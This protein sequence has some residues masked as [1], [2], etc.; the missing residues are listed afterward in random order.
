MLY[1]YPPGQSPG[2]GKPR[3]FSVSSVIQFPDRRIQA[4]NIEKII[5]KSIEDPECDNVFFYSCPPN[6]NPSNTELLRVIR[7]Y[8]EEIDSLRLSCKGKVWSF[9]CKGM[10]AGA[11]VRAS[12]EVHCGENDDQF[13]LV[14]GS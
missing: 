11:Y 6:G 1:C 13:T 4:S 8:L 10:S 12:V 9:S 3:N 5:R 14:I 7:N 2:E